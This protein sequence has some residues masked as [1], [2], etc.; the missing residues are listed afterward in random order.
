MDV[1]GHVL[2]TVEV[3]WRVHGLPYA[4]LGRVLEKLHV[5]SVKPKSLLRLWPVTSYPTSEGTRARPPPEAPGLRVLGSTCSP[6][7]RKYYRKRYVQNI[8]DAQALGSFLPEPCKNQ[9]RHI[10]EHMCNMYRQ[11]I[12]G[13]SFLAPLLPYETSRLTEEVL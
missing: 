3:V 10:R 1:V 12:E 13:L 2:L 6:G 4:V 5:K 7:R 11:H 8:S 9:G